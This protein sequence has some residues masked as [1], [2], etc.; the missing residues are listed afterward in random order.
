MSGKRWAYGITVAAAAIAASL[1]APRL[2][3]RGSRDATTEARIQKG[4]AIA[5]VPLDLDGKDRDLVALGSYI[6][7]AQAGCN[8]CHTE[9]SYEP[10]HDPFQGGDGK[11]NTA[12][13]LKGGKTAAPGLVTPDLTPDAQGRPGGLTLEQFAHAINGGHDPAKPGRILQVMPWPVYC[14][15]IPEDQR[16]VYEYLRAIPSSRATPSP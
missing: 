4:L 5:P 3:A 15:M 11:V 16:A 14:Q 7:N 13:Y 10:G 6:V 12:R 8:D 9:P 1:G 2:L